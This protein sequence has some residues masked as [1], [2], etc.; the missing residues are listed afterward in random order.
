M[1]SSSKTPQKIQEEKQREKPIPKPTSYEDSQVMVALSPWAPKVQRRPISSPDLWT[2]GAHCQ[3][4]QDMWAQP[5]RATV[6]LVSETGV[7]LYVS[8]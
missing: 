5:I 8:L 1:H 4:S 6:L 7:Y 3:S 2:N